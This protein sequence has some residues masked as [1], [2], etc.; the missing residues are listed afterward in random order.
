MKLKL[1]LALGF[2]FITSLVWVVGISSIIVT[3][4]NV[5][6]TIE[7]YSMV[8]VTR[9]THYINKDILSKIEYFLGRT[10]GAT[11]QKEVKKSNEYYSKVKDPIKLINSFDKEWIHNGNNYFLKK[12]LINNELS[13]AFIEES[14]LFEK[15]N[16]KKIITEIL[17]TDSLGALVAQANYASDY[18][19]ADEEWWQKAKRDK[20]Y[21]SDFIYD[22]SSKTYATEVCVRIED[23]YGKFIGVLKATISI[24]NILSSVKEYLS[25]SVLVK[26]LVKNYII[27]DQKGRILFSRDTSFRFL[28]IYPMYQLI[29]N[30]ISNR[31]YLLEF[32]DSEGNGIIAFFRTIPGISNLQNKWVLIV[33]YKNDEIFSSTKVLTNQILIGCFL[34]TIFGFIVSY[35]IANKMVAPL[36][37]LIVA[38]NK[39]SEGNL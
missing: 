35:F 22:E 23:K 12:N 4:N 32:K 14:Q 1:K 28:D 3:K 15:E 20:V 29:L 11:L 26:S 31:K 9:I 18:Y 27:F 38:T 10:K 7:Q 30:E 2:A 16:N 34:I 36:K 37:S 24:E 19:Q 6:D 33:E 5:T 39:I 17:V 13:Q 25:Q 8:N 21:V